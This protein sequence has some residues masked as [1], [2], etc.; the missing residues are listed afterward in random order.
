VGFDPR[1]KNSQDIEA[2]LRNQMPKLE[3][4]SDEAQRTAFLGD[5][6]TRWLIRFAITVAY[7]CARRYLGGRWHGTGQT[8]FEEICRAMELPLDVWADMRR[9]VASLFEDSHCGHDFLK[10]FKVHESDFATREIYLVGHSAGSIGV[11]HFLAKAQM[12]GISHKFKVRLAAPAISCQSFV[13]TLSFGKQRIADIRTF[14]LND[15][16]EQD[17]YL[18][19]KLVPKPLDKMYHG[20]LLWLVSGGL[21]QISDVPLLGMER[22]LGGNPGTAGASRPRVVAAPSLNPAEQAIIEKA[23]EILHIGNDP[24]AITFTPTPAGS[25]ARVS[26]STTTHGGFDE[27]NEGYVD[28][29]LL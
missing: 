4:F 15:Q 24:N 3:D 26:C 7:R 2:R 23:L 6:V 5:P 29:I 9:D 12:M 28:A 16:V 18:L 21:E 11:S 1:N 27:P 13:D 8:I 20:S 17:E 19:D 10:E 14:C 25:A 22:F